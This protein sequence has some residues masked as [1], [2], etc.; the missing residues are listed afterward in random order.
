MRP[1]DLIYN[2]VFP[3]AQYYHR[4]PNGDE[5]WNL[6]VVFPAQRAAGEL[7]A[8]GEEGSGRA[9]LSHGCPPGGVDID[10]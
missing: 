9:L 3:G 2:G 6:T 4:Y 7:R 8:D 1:N 10:A 5:V